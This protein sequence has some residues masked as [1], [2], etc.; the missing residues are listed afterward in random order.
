MPMQTLGEG[1][2]EPNGFGVLP[3]SRDSRFRVL[4][5]SVLGLQ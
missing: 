5:L 1:A 3:Q 4:G 2:P